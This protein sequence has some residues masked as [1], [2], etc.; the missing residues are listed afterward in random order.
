MTTLSFAAACVPGRTDVQCLHRWQK[1]LNPEL[2]KGP[3]TKEVHIKVYILIHIKGGFSI[4]INLRIWSVQEDDLIRELVMTNGK[5]N[6]SEIA[7]ALPG[8]IGKQCRER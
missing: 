6:W 2:I 1:V 4:S 7:K 3:W 5:K 8:R